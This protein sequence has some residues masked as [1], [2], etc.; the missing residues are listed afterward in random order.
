[1]PRLRRRPRLP[2]F[3]RPIRPL[4]RG[5]P[6]LLL[7]VLAVLPA[8]FDAPPARAQEAAVGGLIGL[9]LPIGARPVGRGRTAVAV[10]GD[11]HGLPYNPA[12]VVGIERGAVAFSRF[13]A[14]EATDLESNFL[15]GAA[16]TRFGTVAVQFG[17]VDFGSI[18][19]TGTS[20]E[21]TGSVD[22]AEW[23]LG[24]T[25]AGRWRERVAWGATARWY[26]SDLG[27]A[28]AGGPAFDAGV[29][30]TPVATLPLDLA[31][32][33]RNAGPDLEFDV[34]DGETAR[35]RLPT[36][37][38]LGAAVRPESFAG[39]P[40]DVR[41]A[42]A[43]DFEIDA[44]DAS[45]TSQHGGVEVVFRDLLVVRGGVL[46]VDN[47]FVEEEED[48]RGVGGS[49]GVGIRYEGFE[50][51]VAREVSVSELGDETHFSVG[52]RF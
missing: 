47:P 16:P 37:V 26:A 35:E 36:R 52:W 31:A 33:V 7:A 19:L 43:F 24:V 27:V 10:L 9:S 41:V 28:D 38:R 1:M 34:G 20:P 12:A 49:F 2:T 46:A 5:V 15:A 48:D 50:A 3:V 40:S 18:P 39:L 29:V 44:R 23:W 21:P 17:Y 42:F 25:W 14:A 8:Q 32:S 11:V 13:E 51:D 22:V 45:H 6:R 4:P 30:A